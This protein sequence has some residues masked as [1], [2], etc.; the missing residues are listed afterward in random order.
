MIIDG[1]G[2]TFLVEIVMCVSLWILVRRA[3]E[4]KVT[5]TIHKIPGVD[6]LNEAVGRATELGGTVIFAP[7]FGQVQD[8]QTL[9]GL[10]VLSH[11]AA[12]CAKY[13]TRIV[14]S[15]GL[16]SVYP[17]AAAV[18]K[19]AFISEG[20]VDRYSD[21][22]VRFYSE[23]SMGWASGTI[24]VMMREKVAANIFIGAFWAESLFMAEAGNMIGAT[25]IAGT[26]NTHQIPFFV[27][28]CDYT[29]IGEEIYAA[30]AYLNPD[31]VTTS[32]LVV[33]DWGKVFGLLVIVLGS[34]LA[35]FGNTA[36]AALLDM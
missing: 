36:L 11:V 15:V 31:P 10:S 22:D 2:V 21:N 9:A 1:M 4:G 19:Q 7:G 18:T 16:A 34:L 30:S 20:K 29:L 8:S 13:D 17:I 5:A 3:K 25:Q 27:A 28:A 35:T 14:V 26:A 6:A 24:G 23:I 12:M 32:G 33:Q